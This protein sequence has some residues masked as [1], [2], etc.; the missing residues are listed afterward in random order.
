MPNTQSPSDQSTLLGAGSSAAGSTP[1]RENISQAT[2]TSA[3][4][5][6]RPAA[7]LAWCADIKAQAPR[8]S[9]RRLVA[10]LALRLLRHVRE[11]AVVHVLL[12]VG[13]DIARNVLEV[14]HHHRD[15]ERGLVMHQVV[16]VGVL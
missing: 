3:G 13:R 6:T 1:E 9:W 10:E 15:G 7:R 5:T 11:E 12:H 16:R 2:T 14:L 8:L 4:T